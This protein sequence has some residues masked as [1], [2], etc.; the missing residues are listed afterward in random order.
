MV[1]ISIKRTCGIAA[2]LL[3]NEVIVKHK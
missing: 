2:V 3:N 1:C